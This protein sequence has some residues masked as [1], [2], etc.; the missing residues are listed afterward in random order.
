MMKQCLTLV[1]GVFLTT[2]TTLTVAEVPSELTEFDGQFPMVSGKGVL[3]ITGGDYW[4]R[5]MYEDGEVP[6]LS[7]YELPDGIYRYQFRSI[8]A[9]GKSSSRQKSVL[10]GNDQ[11]SPGKRSRAATVVSGTIEISDGQ[12]TYR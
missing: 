11:V 12:A 1:L 4:H 7:A 5:Q 8:P 6:Y 2:A 3:T 10:M 9:N